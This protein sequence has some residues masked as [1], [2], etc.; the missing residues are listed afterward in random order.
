MQHVA[1]LSA[2]LGEALGTAAFTA[3]ELARACGMSPDWVHARVEAGVLQVDM[4]SGA[5]RFD[6]VTLV[7]ARRIAQ[8]ESTYDADPQL[9]AL[10][11]DLIEEVTLLR[12]R[13]AA[14]GAGQAEVSE[15]TAD[16]DPQ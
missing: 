11:T 10:T 7:R 2:E 1:L 16:S 4:A 15:H 14:L 13:L 8:L 9:A 12:R 6:S 5:W 3:D